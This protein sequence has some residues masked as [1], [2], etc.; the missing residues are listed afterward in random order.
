MNRESW[1]FYQREEVAISGKTFLFNA[2]IVGA[3]VFVYCTN[4]GGTTTV[5][6]LYSLGQFTMAGK[7]ALTWAGG[8][9]ILR[10]RDFRA[11][12]AWKEPRE[13]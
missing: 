9:S 8:W 2:V 13:E 3:Y 1:N 6:G 11:G 5:T 7:V 4:G 10:I 12:N